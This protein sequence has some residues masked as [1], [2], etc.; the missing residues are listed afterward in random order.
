MV[1]K[2]PVF[3][4]LSDEIFTDREE[5]LA[6]LKNLAYE[7]KFKRYI[8]HSLLGHRRIGKTE[9]MKRAYNELFW[10]QDEIVPVY[11]D[12]DQLRMTTELFA[13][14][15]LSRFLSQ[16]LAFKTKNPSIVNQR[17]FLEIA[18]EYAQDTDNH[19][20][21]KILDEYQRVSQ[22]WMSW[23]TYDCAV[24]APLDIS[25]ETGEPMY[26]M[27][28]EF[29]HVIEICDENGLPANALGKFRPPIESRRCP[30]L[31]SGSAVTLMTQ[32]ILGRGSLFG[33]TRPIYIRGLEGYHVEELCQK[34]GKYHSVSI[35]SEMS[36]EL[37][38]RTGGNPF[39]LNCIFARARK[40]NRDLVDYTAVNSVISY[41][42]TQGTIWSEL[43]R[44]LNYYF[45]T[46]NEKDIT[47]NIF[48]FASRYQDEEIKPKEV[49]QNM[50][51]FNVTE[52]EVREVLLALSRA[53]LIQ[54][55]LAGSTFFNIKDP[56]LREFADAWARV[57]VEN[58]TWEEAED[59][60][61]AKYNKLSGEYRDFKG[62]TAEI[63][64][65][66]LMT[67][68]NY[69]EVDGKE[70]FNYDSQVLLPKF[71]WI[72]SK[73]VKLTTTREYQLDVVGKRT[74]YLWLAEVKYT[75]KPIGLPLV[76]KF[77]SACDVAIK[78][79]KGE[80]VTRWYISTGD[81]TRP[82]IKYLKEK[83]FLYSNREEVNKLLRWFGLREL[84]VM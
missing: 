81:F 45:V 56:I 13:S 54:E 3:E 79:F 23:M 16:Y 22:G 46:I 71:I 33:R 19:V 41:E 37:Y 55:K 11:I 59:E 43:Y 70:Y 40:L 20:V 1:D 51:H 18:R 26:I 57:D 36:G 12:F 6:Q 42:L 10:E 66:F 74:P 25:R 63:F 68:F 24:N 52:Q 39:Y 73:K 58:A 17:G 27:L 50:R 47:K 65:Q 35:T 82:A 64:V 9:V 44:Q 8:S 48:Y 7:A 61:L 28:D 62:Y 2:Q 21:I 53:D 77:E 84:P 4:V 29:Q 80:E 15:Y 60:L 69:Q 49:A 67:K 75:E 14:E 31:I 32:D 83:G 34:L 72:D 30:H 78:T 5:L 76:K 38:R